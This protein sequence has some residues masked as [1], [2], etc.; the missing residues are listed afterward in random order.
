MSEKANVVAV[1]LMVGVLGCSARPAPELVRSSVET[2]PGYLWQD[3]GDGIHLHTRAD[4][5]AGPVDGNS[6][7]IVNDED[8]FVVDTHIAPAAARAVIAR[9]R[10]LTDK[11]VTHVINTHWHDD[12]VNGNH[13]YRQ[14]FPDARI[15][16]H[17]ATLAALEREWQPMEAQREHAYASITPARI[18]AIADSIAGEDPDRATTFRIYAGYVEA[19]KP[20]LPTMEL[21]YPDQVFDDSLRFQRGNRTIVVKW[22]GRGN[23]DGDAIVWLPAE[24]VLV[25]GD[26]VVDPI[27]FAYDSP[28]VE[29]ITTLETLQSLPAR[30]VIPGHGPARRDFAHVEEVRGLLDATVAAVRDAHSAGTAWAALEGAVTLP[31]WEQRFTEG[32]PMRRHAW[33]QYFI[34][35]GVKSA[36]VSLGYEAPENAE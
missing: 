9:I 6:V 13:A 7:V 5:L 33:G 19:L 14:A 2:F 35:P 24:R 3:L 22:V 26:L 1:L 11:P 23:T 27:P 17:R 15:V 4:P 36:W 16:A 28:M 21:V 32:D 31:D 29:W 12:H 10:A 34:A 30:V 8:V 20:E 18:R 25:T